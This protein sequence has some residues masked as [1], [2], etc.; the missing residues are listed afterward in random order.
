M[1]PKGAAEKPLEMKLS[2]SVLDS[3]GINLYS[4]AAAVMAELVANAWDAEATQVKIDWNVTGKGRSVRVV[5]NGNGMSRDELNE[6]FLNIGY[7]KR[8][9]DGSTSPKLKRPF[10]GRKGIGKLSVFSLAEVVE[11]A[12]VRKGGKPNAFRIVVN[13]LRRAIEAD[14]PYFP[15]E[16]KAPKGTPRR[17]TLVLL[18]ELKRERTSIV[19]AALR[20]RLARRFDI[21]HL[22]SEGKDRFRIVID[23]KPVTHRDRT[24]L[25]KLEFVWEF[26]KQR[27]DAGDL[28]PGIRRTTIRNTSI[29]DHP[30]WKVSGWFGSATKPQDLTSD[31]EERVLSDIIV[32]ARGR[33]IQE[34]ILRSLGISRVFLNYVTGQIRADFLDLDTEDDIATS[35]RQRLMED[36]ERVEALRK[37]LRKKLVEAAQDWTEWRNEKKAD[38]IEKEN[39]AIERWLADL[40]NEQKAP[41]KKLVGTIGGLEFPEDA[42][43]DARVKLLQA[44]VVAFERI[45]LREDTKQLEELSELESA[46]LLP[47]L[48]RLESYEGAVYRDL[49]KGRL[50]AIHAFAEDLKNDVLEKIL[51]EKVKGN[52][53][54]LDPSWDRVQQRVEMEEHLFRMA[55]KLGGKRPVKDALK[56]IDLRYF[57]VQNR[58][59]I[60]ELKRHSARAD[61]DTL[62][63]QGLDYTKALEQVLQDINQPMADYEIVFVVGKEPTAKK[64]PPGTKPRDYVRKRLGE[65]NGRVLMY[66]ELLQGAHNQYSDF[67]EREVEVS[68]VAEILDQLDSPTDPD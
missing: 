33:P 17:G 28:P 52:L 63:D 48:A 5:D 2:M 51:Q 50:Q 67:L 9:K 44:G 25:K 45:R 19:A 15:Q 40:P 14:K 35:D 41:A 59:V 34:G 36:D 65:I 60:V 37:F 20:K 8:L 58:H 18:K 6:K 12:S 16:I 29:P 24:E 49:V 27:I 54:L 53:W 23:G 38:E 10:M 56:R 43:E 7:R 3:L 21:F 13:D 61:A 64:A 31:G 4:N 55:E 47:L 30:S 1:S 68:R 11:V 32:L 46:D 66:G 26:G 22:E 39:P 57:S 42:E 62:Y